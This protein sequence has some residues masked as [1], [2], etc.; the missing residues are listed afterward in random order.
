MYI[1]YSDL[2]MAYPKDLYPL[3]EI[4][5]KVKS[6][7]GFKWKYFLDAYKGYH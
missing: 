7:L 6:L 5:Q 4:D 3:P 1:N 2:N